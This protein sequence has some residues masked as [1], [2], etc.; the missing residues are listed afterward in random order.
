M[1]C[2]SVF[3]HMQSAWQFMYTIQRR[4]YLMAPLVWSDSLASMLGF[5]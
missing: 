3:G 4:S 5:E 2:I 1:Q